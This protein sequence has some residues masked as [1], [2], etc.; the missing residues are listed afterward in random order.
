MSRW[1]LHNAYFW[2]ETPLLRPLLFAALGIVCYDR[3]WIGIAPNAGFAILLI[4]G[5]CSIA[6]AFIRQR[7]VW[8]E[9]LYASCFAVFFS[10]IGWYSYASSDVRNSGSWAGKMTDTSGLSLVRIVDEPQRRPATTKLRVAWLAEVR[11]GK[12]MPATGYALLY[13]YRSGPQLSLSECDTLLVPSRWLTIR[14]SGNPF[15]FDNATFQR[16]K[17][18]L[19]QQFL[20][21]VGLTV[22][23]KANPTETTRLTQ[24]H[25]WADR[26]LRAYIRDSATL[27]LLQAMLLGDESGFDGEL[28]LAYSQTGIIHIVSISGSH[29]AVLFLVVTGV[30]FWLKGKRGAWVKYFVGLALIWLYVLVAGAPP[31]ALRSALMFT[32]IALAGISDQEGHSLNTLVCAAFALLLGEPAWLFSVGFQLS[33]GAVLSM[34]LFYAPIYRLWYWPKKTWITRWLWAAVAASFAAEILTAP[35]VIYYFHNFPLLFLFANLIA[36]VMAGICALVGGL[37]IIALC[38]IPPLAKLLGFLVTIIVTWFNAAIVCMQGWNVTALQH[39]RLTGPELLLCYLLI[40]GLGVWWL[41]KTRR[42]LFVALPAACALLLILTVDSY[43]TRRQKRL[44][45]YNNGR[46]PAVELIRGK[47]FE[48]LAGGQ[49]SYNAVAAHTGLG[50]WRKKSDTTLTPYFSFGGKTVLVLSDSTIQSYENPLLVDVLILARPLR[51]I[52]VASFLQ[53]FSPKEIVLAVRPS[54]YHLKRWT[55]SCAAHGIRLHSVDRDGAYIRE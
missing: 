26:Q 39:L 18:V 44:I 34:L 5:L 43:Q 45:V 47:Y 38:W 37:A 20:S 49:V 12:T 31:S 17:N 3:S 41:E 32:V 36:A 2:Q 11:D 24:I 19:H 52:R 13:I 53:T 9:A 48:Q 46:S 54:A 4:S 1:P 27:G 42:G 30:F 6:L 35:L 7:P 23:G 40:A 14:N 15:E 25:R 10:A 29:V 50:A 28:R 16:R 33:F 8:M 55:D 22:F 21:P 51:Q